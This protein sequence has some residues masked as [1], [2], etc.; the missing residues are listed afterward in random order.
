MVENILFIRKIKNFY[1]NIFFKLTLLN[2]KLYFN[3]ELIINRSNK[4]FTKFKYKIHIFTCFI[5]YIFKKYIYTINHKRI[6]IN[7]FFFS[8]W[9][10]CCGAIL[11]TMMR[12]ELA[13]PGSPY[14]KGDSLRY[15]QVITAHGL[16]MI[17]FVVVPILFG[18]FA[19][20]LIP[21]H[22]GSKDVAFPRLN[23]IGFWILPCGF[24]LVAKIAFLRT[25]Y[26]RYY[27]KMSFILPFFE[28]NTK[29][30][31]DSLIEYYN[32]NS[33]F[34]N[35]N[36]TNDYN[37][38]WKSRKK[39]NI[40]EYKFFSFIPLQLT[41]QKH[42][43]SYPESFWYAA[44]RVIKS[45]RKKTYVTKCSNRTL[46]TSGWAF[47]TPFS[48]NIKFTG[49]GS[50]DILIISV[51]FAGI[52]TTISFT[53]LLITKRTLSMP[54][55]RNRK[56]LLP[57]VTISILLTLRMLLLITPVLAAGMIMLLLDRHWQT[58]F[59]EFAY[60]GDVVLFQHLFWFFGHPEVYVLI[61][62][63]FGFI[64]MILPY[65]NTRRIASKHHLVWAIYIM[66][67]MGFVVWGHHMYLVGLDHRSRSL[68]STITIM[69]SLPATIKMVNW[70]LTLLNGGFKIDIP[71]LFSIA[72][73]VVFIVGGFT[74]MWLSHVGLNI[75]MHDTYY[76]VAHFHLMLS[77]ATMTGI[78]AGFYYYF[79]SF[80]GIKYSHFF[81][82]L[83]LIYY[84][85]GQW[86][87]FL[88]MF[89]LGFSGL[90]RR[91]HDYPVMFTGWQNMATIG[92]FITLTGIFFFFLMLFDSH[93]ENKLNVP[94]TL[95][96]PRWYKRI[97][98]YL[99]KISYLNQM[100]KKSKKYPNLITQKLILL[101]Y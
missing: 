80:F 90:P 18:G 78:F 11:A 43:F 67:Y 57:F 74:G 86:L 15:L 94:S 73:I 17:F 12:L 99:F 96:I 64:N 89:W 29:R 60:G 42:I 53:N 30:I 39:I 72:Y 59:F 22:I 47:I 49:I 25:Q 58:T 100:E 2:I 52:S 65:S 51:I 83:H 3:E 38:F 81:A 95:G 88:P 7:Y 6:A 23:S 71:L 41:L 66:A 10:G 16:I 84:V 21:Y 97:Q 13:I 19:N 85:G 54:G 31:T 32:F 75:S 27:D 20:F 79:V 40:D 70:T 44:N 9:S 98:Y 37:I 35:F 14:F 82:H 8:F 62:P 92:H 56:N 26:W 61:I 63:T 101:I 46:T 28:K 1:K 36:N 91:V 77:G 34:W 5:K 87:T 4:K 24:L 50:Q 55:L 68:Y 76:V 48:S 69:I 45:R 93:Y 33:Y